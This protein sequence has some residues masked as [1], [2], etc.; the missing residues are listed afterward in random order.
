MDVLYTGLRLLVIV[1]SGAAA[2]IALTHYLVRQG[3]LQPFGALPRFVRRTSDPLLKPIERK[4]LGAG[5]N[6][7]DASYWLLGGTVIGGLAV[8]ALFRWLLRTVSQ[9]ISAGQAGPGALVAQVVVWGFGLCT[10]ALLIRVIGS[11]FGVSPYAAW[12]R[13]VRWLTDW[14]LVPLQRIVPPLGPLDVTPI[15]AYVVLM[16]L[17][18]LVL[19]LLR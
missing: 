10:M 6:P 8:L 14:I 12:M 4:L 16:L 3:T 5:G 19:G 15:V 2:G 18:S 13:P 11:W 17:Q 1:A 9:A 7:Q